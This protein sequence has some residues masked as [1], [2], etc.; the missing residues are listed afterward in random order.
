MEFIF[1]RFG[2]VTIVAVYLLIAVGGVV[3]CTGS[4]MG[5]PDWPKCFGQWVP[6]T[7]LSQL[8]TDYKTRFKVV[9]KE[10][11]DFDVFK[12]WTE[13]VNR[14]IGVLIGFF[15][16]LTLLGSLVYWRKD[17]PVFW[18][19][20]LSFLL[21]A[22]Q[23]WLGA[24]VVASNLNPFII[25]LHMLLALVIVMALIYAVTR[26]YTQSM[27]SLYPTEGLSKLNLFLT[28]ALALSLLQVLLGTQ[29]RE[30]VDHLA[31]LNHDQN[32]HL[33]LD[34]IGSWFIA[35]RTLAWAVIAVNAYVG[36]LAWTYSKQTGPVWQWTVVVL[37]VLG[38][39]VLSGLLL[40]Y[41][42]LPNYMQPVHLLFGSVLFGVQFILLML[43]NKH[44][45]GQ[46]AA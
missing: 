25:T 20:L 6:P 33:W 36:W 41:L 17:K 1:K 27:R 13:Y 9:G 29:V 40:V 44:R 38:L 4:G 7:D 34:E 3:R 28:I 31:V 37:V 14:L 23:G 10:I 5:C 15:I 35:H 32:R 26:S 43:L 42:H 8:P 12:T 19:S 11:A 22:F 46:Q 21:V 39:E 24:K 16:F 45:I 30:G 2:V 18:L